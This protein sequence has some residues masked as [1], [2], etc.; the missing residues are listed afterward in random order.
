MSP[1]H[2]CEFGGCT[3]SG[4]TAAEFDF[5]LSVDDREINS[6]RPTPGNAAYTLSNVI[7]SS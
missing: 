5:S 3:T 6:A 7:F 2:H 1:Q 4:M